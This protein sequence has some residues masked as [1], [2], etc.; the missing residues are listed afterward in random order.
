MSSRFKNI[1]DKK[2]NILSKILKVDPKSL[3][4]ANASNSAK[5]SK[6]SRSSSSGMY[7]QVITRISTC[8]QNLLKTK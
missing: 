6:H 2:I 7:T 4:E 1:A 8:R 5:S 3:R